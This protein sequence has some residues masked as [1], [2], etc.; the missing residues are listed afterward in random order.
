LFGGGLSVKRSGREAR[1]V[2]R[3]LGE[4]AK[5][6][7][8]VRQFLAWFTVFDAAHRLVADGFRQLPHFSY[9]SPHIVSDCIPFT[10]DSFRTFG[11][12]RANA[13]LAVLAVLATLAL[14]AVADDGLK[15]HL[16]ERVLRETI[17]P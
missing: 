5:V 11:G 9:A 8:P 7:E 16:R 17:P 10:C 3:L 4:L 1:Q 15:P 2:F 13:P 14:F 6:I 12:V